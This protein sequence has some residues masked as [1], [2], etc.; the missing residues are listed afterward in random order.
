MSSFP[1]N[2]FFEPAFYEFRNEYWSENCL[3]VDKMER[4]LLA[5]IIGN[6]MDLDSHVRRILLN[7]EFSR[8][9]ELIGALQ[10]FYIVLGEKGETIKHYLLK[11][12]EPVLSEEVLMPFRMGIARNMDFLPIK[13][14]HSYLY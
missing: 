13:S 10:D 14:P 1:L 6:P 7:I 12:S 5:K 4:H 8:P 11:Y 3:D 2:S 9:D